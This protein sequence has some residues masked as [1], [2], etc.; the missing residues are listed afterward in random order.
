MRSRTT[1]KIIFTAPFYRACGAQP[2]HLLGVSHCGAIKRVV[3]PAQPIASHMIS[4]HSSTP[5]P[6]AEKREKTETDLE[7][8]EVAF[9]L[10]GSCPSIVD[11]R[12]DLREGVLMEVMN[13]VT[14]RVT[15]LLIFSLINFVRGL[16]MH[17]VGSLIKSK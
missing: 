15:V 14:P 9:E 4:L 8:Q 13:N 12:L 1:H 7:R 3:A 16:I 10:T 6:V 11:L 17:Q 5:F 2:L